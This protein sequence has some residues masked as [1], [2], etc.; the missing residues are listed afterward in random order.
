MCRNRHKV[1][2]S[3]YYAVKGNDEKHLFTDWD[4]CKEFLAGKKGYK[5]K[6]FSSK[7]EAE[8]YF[9]GEDYAENAVKE[10]MNN[11]YA[12]AYT[13]G[14]YEESTG[15]YSF[16]AITFLPDGR[17]FSFC[18]SGNNSE[19][20][21]SRN[22]AGEIL[23]VLETVKWAFL[24]GCDKL[25]IYHDYEGLSAWA[26]GRWQA[27]GAV[28]VYYMNRLKRYAGALKIV[29]EKVKGHSNNSYNEAVDKLAKAA[30]FEGKKQVVTG[31]GCK[32]SGN[33]E[34]EPLCE[35]I[36]KQTKGV[37]TTLGDD[38]C[39]FENRGK[40]LTVYRKKGVLT[41]CGDGGLLYVHA[42]GYF[43]RNTTIS[44]VNRLIERFFDVDCETESVRGGIETTQFLAEHTDAKNY[45]PYIVFTLID[46]EK[47]IEGTLK[48]KGFAGDK[49]SRAFVKKDG[50]FKAV[51]PFSGAEK[52]EELYSFFYDYRTKLDDLIFTKKECLAFCAMARGL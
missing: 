50:E 39:L 43:Y 20:L 34:Y 35:Y 27:K 22:V 29:F 15:K 3:K 38:Y 42:M 7:K 32:I 30:L 28:S 21:S 4:S 17:Q 48:T 6:S 5:Y 14:S 52:I 12:V 46:I 13:D 33:G 2:L 49:I 18:D 8:C 36:F 23:G 9:S 37:K 44:N 40:K 25:K 41:V 31:I 10:D 1:K 24:N 16:G 11:G 47:R 45:A 51:I 26:E 19:F